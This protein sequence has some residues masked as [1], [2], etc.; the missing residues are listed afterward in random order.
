MRERAAEEIVAHGAWQ[1]SPRDGHVDT[2]RKWEE[3]VVF[4]REGSNAP[5]RDVGLESRNAIHIFLTSPL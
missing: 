3:G 5:K 4:A 2:R 1:I